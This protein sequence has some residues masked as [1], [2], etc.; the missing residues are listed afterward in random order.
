MNVNIGLVLG[1]NVVKGVDSDFRRRVLKLS[2]N[3]V[4]G[5]SVERE[6]R[7]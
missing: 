2:G 7:K 6:L 1:V 3:I 4:W 5:V